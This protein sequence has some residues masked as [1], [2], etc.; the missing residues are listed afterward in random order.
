MVASG[1]PQR[2]IWSAVPLATIAPPVRPT[3]TPN[4]MAKPGDTRDSSL[5]TTCIIIGFRRASPPI[6]PP[7]SSSASPPAGAPASPARSRSMRFLI[8]APSSASKP[9]VRAI[10]LNGGPTVTPAAPRST[11]N[12]ARPRP[13]GGSPRSILA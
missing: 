9:N 12:V 8:D 7:P 4:P 13:S 2:S 11:M 1:S 5:T 3:D 6:T 10:F